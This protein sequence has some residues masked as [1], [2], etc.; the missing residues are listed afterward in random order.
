MGPGH[1][2][3]EASV[4]LFCGSCED[5]YSPVR[6]RD[7]RVARGLPRGSDDDDDDDDIFG[8]DDGGDGVSGD[9][10][11]SEA[12]ETEAEAGGVSGSRRRRADAAAAAPA[13]PRMARAPADLDGAFWGPSFPHMLILMRSHATLHQ[14]AVATY[15]PRIYG[16]RVFTQRGRVPAALGDGRGAYAVAAAASAAAAAGSKAAAAAAASGGGAGAGA[17]PVAPPPVLQSLSEH[18]RAAA[19]RVSGWSLDRIG[20]DQADGPDGRAYVPFGMPSYAIPIDGRGAKPRSSVDAP[21]TSTYP[22]WRRPAADDFV[23]EED[24]LED[25]AARK[26]AKR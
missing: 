17:M 14:R 18:P 4:K 15:V 21:L 10:S 26:K 5:V 6:S 22:D 13:I 2:L 24:L 25:D 19:L 11:G 16:F 8:S 1:S 23:S 9:E 7:A 3:G 12:T 20:A